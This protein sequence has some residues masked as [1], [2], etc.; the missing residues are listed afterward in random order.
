MNWDDL[1]VFLTVVRQPNLEKAASILKMN[2][3]TASRRVKRLEKTLGTTLFERTRNG[4]LLT[5]SG[6]SLAKNVEHIETLAMNIVSDTPT[7][8]SAAG[9]IRLGVPEGIGT[10]IIA[11]ALAEFNQQHPNIHIDLIALSGF[12][13]VPKRE[14]DM[15]LLL[16]RPITGRLK[17]RRLSNYSLGLFGSEDYVSNAAPISTLS[18]LKNHTLIG[19]VDD[20]IYSGQLRYFDDILPDL[21]PNLQSTSINAQLQMVRSGIG[22]GILPRFITDKDASL[23]NLLPRQVCVR[24]TFWLAIHE[25]VASLTRNRLMS[26]FLAEKLKS[27]P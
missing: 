24:R 16:T 10:A 11:P 27:L 6:E 25:D 14:A 26:D 20:L 8:Q 17:I 5:P 2:A 4:H 15:S 13:S 18:D 9:N 3:T 19:Y 12:V 23:V 1:K 21:T 7:E 22:L